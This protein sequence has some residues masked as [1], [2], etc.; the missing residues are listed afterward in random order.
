MWRI[1]RERVLLAA[2]PAALLLQLAHPLIA[3][4]VAAHGE[5]RSDPFQRLRSTLDSTL[6]IAFGD[7]AQATGAAARVAA[8]HRRVTGRLASTCGRFPVGSPYS[9]SDPSLAVWVHAT[10]VVTALDA[11]HR[12]VSPLGPGDRARYYQEAKRFASMFGVPQEALPETYEG[13]EGYVLATQEETLHVGRVA[14]ELA[15]DILRPGSAGPVLGLMAT[16]IPVLTAGLLPTT[17][18]RAYGL[19]W[20]ARERWSFHAC[21]LLFRAAV[22]M[23]PPR[24][25][26]WPHYLDARRRSEEL[27]AMRV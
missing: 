21:S 5:F 1:G 12:F 17:I 18:R 4:A 7:R 25:R 20:N 15:S 24:V 27:G 26:F 9:A 3:A 6:L 22:R 19:A 13:F 14:R 8:T 11:F 2:G 10:L 23:A 16:P